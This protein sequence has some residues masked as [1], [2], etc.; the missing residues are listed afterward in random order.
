MTI[1]KRLQS[2][3]DQL[4]ELHHDKTNTRIGHY[5]KGFSEACNILLP[6]VEKLR[7]A[8]QMYTDIYTPNNDYAYQALRSIEEFMSDKSEGGDE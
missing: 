3:R 4:A 5:K 7:E 1:P 8:L 6:E 2:E